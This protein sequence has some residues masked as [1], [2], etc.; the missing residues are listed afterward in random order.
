M[1]S[2]YLFHLVQSEAF[3]DAAN[4]S[5]GT[6]MPRADWNV[7]KDFSTRIP[8]PEEQ[9]EIASLL[10]SK[11]NE[12]SRRQTDLTHLTEEKKALMQQLLTGKRRVGLENKFS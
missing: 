11:L 5:S 8:P 9:V 4:K 6:H 3:I 2:R 7:V 1:N 10:D 12:I